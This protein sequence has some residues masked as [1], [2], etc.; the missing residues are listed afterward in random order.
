MSDK[1]DRPFGEIL[2][3]DCAPA[4]I[5]KAKSSHFFGY[6]VANLT[7]DEVLMALGHALEELE[8]ERK[9]HQEDVEFLDEIRARA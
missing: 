8:H 7:P 2:T 6:S 3:L 9:S 4:M 5:E 1:P